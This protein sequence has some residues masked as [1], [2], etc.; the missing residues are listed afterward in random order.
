M[1]LNDILMK[2]VRREIDYELF[3]GKPKRLVS[4]V[5]RYRQEAKKK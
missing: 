5:N 3:D 4:E 1:A 2:L